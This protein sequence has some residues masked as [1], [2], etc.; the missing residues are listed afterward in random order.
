VEIDAGGQWLFPGL[1][2]MHVHLR[3][4][5]DES[6]ETVATGLRAAVAGGV[7]T[8]GVMPNTDPP[9]DSVARVNRLLGT[10]ASQVPV[11]VVP[12]PCVTIGRKGRETVDFRELARWGVRAFSD[13]GDP[14]HDSGLLLRSL[15]A[16]SE[17]DGVIIEHPE[18]RS[19]SGGAVNLGR[20]SERMGVEGIPATAETSDVAR[21]LEVA[22]ASRGRL[23]LTHLSL[24]RSVELA[25]SGLFRD[26]GVTLDV[27]P[28]HLALDEDALEEH[29]TMAKMNPP[30]RTPEQRERLVRM[31]REGMA[32]AVASDHA[33]HSAARKDLP[34]EA[35]AFGIS[36]LETLLPVT[37][38]VLRGA[39]MTP[40]EVL[41][42]LI[43]GPAGILGLTPPDLGEGSAAECVLF[44]P[45]EE[46]TIEG[47]GTFSG[48]SNTPFLRRRLRGR[49]KAVWIGELVYRDGRFVQD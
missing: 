49:V 16:V 30:L 48:S 6:S 21:C 26:A 25:R 13:D 47:T 37:L 14:V 10:A 45:M 17:F 20:M 24:P 41:R 42:L 18:D 22:R 33:P 35:A 29:G 7:T 3:E 38:E 12:I 15:D 46:Y 36:G 43:T 19:L 32:D 23:H 31:V 27:T 44:D 34:L 28:H 40:L 11:R 9:M 2:D 4:P 39:G 5:G 1:I 8:V